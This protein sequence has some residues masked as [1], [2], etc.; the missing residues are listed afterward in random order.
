[1]FVHPTTTGLDPDISM[2]FS[3]GHWKKDIILTLKSLSLLLTAVCSQEEL[4]QLPAV[5]A[6]DSNMAQLEL[7]YL[8]PLFAKKQTN[9]DAKGK[10]HQVPC[11]PF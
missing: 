5:E 3:L 10:K 1:M 9:P 11:T 7:H 4:K 8:K 2:S 6:E